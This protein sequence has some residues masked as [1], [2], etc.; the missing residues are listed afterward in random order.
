MKTAAA[1]LLVDC[2][3]DLGECCLWDELSNLLLWVDIEA[4]QI[5]E[6]DH[7]SG[8]ARNWQMP[9]RIG[10]I[11]LR[12]SGGLVAALESGFAYVDLQDGSVSWLASVRTGKSRTRLNDSRTDRQGRFLSGA[13]DESTERAKTASVFRLDPDLTV[14]R[15]LD[16]VDIS[17]SICFSPGGETMYFADTPTS[18]IRSYRYDIETGVPAE[19]RLFADCY[20][21]LPDGSAVDQQ[22]FV[23][24]A[25]FG[26]GRVVRY[27]TDGHVDRVVE[28]PVSH[29]TCVCLGGPA[30]QTLIITSA[31]IELGESHL[32]T[33]PHAGG[34]FALD[35]DV[36]GLPE[37]RFAG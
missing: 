1:E 25:Q 14:H 33:Q 24:N 21:G 30:L 4:G 29:P 18:Q 20:P 8:K 35:V 3:N 19:P 15:I 5:W 13:M 37:S 12:D 9:E 11:G 27:D 31:R 36:P 17:N 23:W 7:Q 22:G 2:K 34:V 26:D 10:G 32:Q 6:R 28:L 16:G